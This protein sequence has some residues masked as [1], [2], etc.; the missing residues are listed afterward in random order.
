M[1]LEVGMQ[2]QLEFNCVTKCHLRHVE[3]VPR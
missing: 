1:L 3:L 2:K